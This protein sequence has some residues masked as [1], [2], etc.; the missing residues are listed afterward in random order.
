MRK[1]KDLDEFIRMLEEAVKS[2]QDD[3]TSPRP[4]FVD[5]AINVCPNMNFNPAEIGIPKANKV[6]VDILETEEKI[7]ALIGLPGM[8]WENIRLCCNGKVLEITA[9][10]PGKPL[11]ETIELPARVIKKG[12]KARLEN[13]I[14]EVILN[15]SKRKATR[16]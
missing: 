8:E 13:G 15:K 5:I 16:E 12:M 14:L 6:P 1:K 10:D 3:G 7:H 11:N 2:M 9:A 4:I